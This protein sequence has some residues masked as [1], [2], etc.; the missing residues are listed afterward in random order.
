[1][2][3][4]LFNSRERKISGAKCGFVS[5]GKEFEYEQT[6]GSY[7]HGCDYAHRVECGLVLGR[8]EGGEDR[9]RADYKV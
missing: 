6:S 5:L 4:W 9:F 8:R 7:R 1:M 3:E 2:E